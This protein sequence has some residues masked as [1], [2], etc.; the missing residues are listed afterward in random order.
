MRPT[1]TIC[2][3]LRGLELTMDFSMPIERKTMTRSHLVERILGVSV[4]CLIYGISLFSSDY[5]SI[6]IAASVLFTV[7]SL[8]HKRNGNSFLS[9]EYIFFV[10]VFI[11]HFGFNYLIL[12]GD[13]RYTFVLRF[14]DLGNET[15]LATSRFSISFVFW[16]SF[17]VI[18]SG[19]EKDYYPLVK[20]PYITK[21]ELS[22][23]GWMFVA[24]CLPFN[25]YVSYIRLVAYVNSGYLATFT[26]SINNFVTTLS[27]GFYVGIVLLILGYRDNK[28]KSFVILLFGLVIS[29]FAMTSGRRS[30]AVVYLIPSITFFLTIFTG[31]KKKLSI[32]RLLMYVLVAY[33]V[34][35]VVGTFGALR[36]TGQSGFKSFWDI[37][38]SNMSFR[39]LNRQLSEF[40]YAAY[41]LGATIEVVPSQMNYGFGLTYFASWATILPNLGGIITGLQDRMTYVTFLPDYYQGALGGS[42]LGEAY[43]NFGAYSFLFFLVVGFLFSKMSFKLK[44]DIKSSSISFVDTCFIVVMPTLFFWVRAYFTAIPR[45]LI[46]YALA[47]YFLKSLLKKE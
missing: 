18:L 2:K 8:L 1:F 3:M 43:Y 32:K 7:F 10:L 30:S 20:R 36:Q 15:I 16:Y 19:R 5:N 37:L 29:L 31:N 35:V 23:I 26:L 13:T 24:V 25:L 44:N 46:W 39:F 14:L 6:T 9:F 45:P 41:T 4:L 21:N 28:R 12:I 47:I 40:G 38:F 22:R 11:F 34:V 42:F 27:N 33:V 17:G